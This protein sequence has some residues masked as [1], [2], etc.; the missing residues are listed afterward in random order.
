MNY[1]IIAAGEGSRL[2]GEGVA[3]PKPLVRINGEALIDRLIRIFLTDNAESIS[4]IVNRE[5][6]EVYE[7]LHDLQLPVPL[8]IIH[9]STP[10]SM[11][12]FYELSSTL[13]GGKF[14]LTTVD[15]VF[16]EKE[17]A[18][19]IR[20]FEACGD[21]GLM[22]VTDFIDDEKPLYVE[23]A[24]DMTIRGFHD[25]NSLANRY[26]SGG[27]Y[28]LTAKSLPILRAAVDSGMSR[29]RN[30][31]RQLVAK[32]LQLRAWPFSKII[33][34]DHSDDI[35]KAESFTQKV[36]P[37]KQS[38][39]II[40]IQR[41][42]VFSPNHIG[43]DAAIFSGAINY[44]RE[45]GHKVRIFTEQEFLNESEN[46]RYVM[47]MMRN[48]GA[49]LR[50]QRWEREGCIAVNSALGI[51]NCERV[52]Q[53]ELFLA[54]GIPYPDSIIVDSH[55][56]VT[57]EIV[58]RGFKSCWLKRGDFHALHREDVTFVRHAE[59]VRE[60]LSEYALRGIGKVVINKHLSGDLIKFYGVAGT[61]F[62]F[63]FY[64]FDDGH[65]KFGYEKINGKSCGIPFEEDRLRDLCDRAAKVL[66]VTVYG[67]DCIVSDDGE[68]RIIDFNDWP[69]FAP[70]RREAIP[71]IGE[72]IIKTFT[73]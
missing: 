25:D 22:A 37:I 60:T 33:D 59:E 63:W 36:T 64:P 46:P 70:C 69:S 27:I 26:V 72:T 24:T 34:V 15:T 4:V 45:K 23:T 1:G 7:H 8:H 19:F 3:V 40:A 10:S 18:A 20:D 38:M 55:D 65:S 56:D 41:A 62:F 12:S 14:C 66:N 30:F 6:N 58:R 51:E 44:V 32:G 13:G 53:T 2:A 48:R 28:C 9:K 42:S 39:N 11:H 47:T 31:Q 35:A 50:L 21:D 57:D 52:R 43:N 17:F 5:M 68:I 49:I 16:D 54:N 61:S 29:M 71:L 67:G 73:Q